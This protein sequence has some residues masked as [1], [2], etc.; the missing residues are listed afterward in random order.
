MLAK[1]FYTTIMA[2]LVQTIFNVLDNGDLLQYFT[3]NLTKFSNLYSNPRYE[4]IL[5]DVAEEPYTAVSASQWDLEITPSVLSNTYLC[6]VHPL[7]STGSLILS[8][9]IVN[10]V[11]L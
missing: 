1:S 7:K 10:L 3:A 4:R 2:D 9:L 8:I 5:K 11:L 6:Q